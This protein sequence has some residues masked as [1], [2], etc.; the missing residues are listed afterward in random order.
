MEY[1]NHCQ[2][3]VSGSFWIVVDDK[4]L[5]WVSDPPGKDIR[6]PLLGLYFPKLSSHSGKFFDIFP[7]GRASIAQ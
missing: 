2:D 7:G 6:E 4:S 3:P 5:T 1:R